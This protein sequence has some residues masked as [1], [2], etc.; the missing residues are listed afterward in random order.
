IIIDST[1]MKLAQNPFVT[2]E[3]QLSR[4]KLIRKKSDLIHLIY[5]KDNGKQET[6]K[7]YQYLLDKGDFA[8]LAA[9]LDKDEPDLTM[10]DEQP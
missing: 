6:I 5:Q 8:N 7:L 3:Y 9:L 4:L 2:R 10:P 1:T